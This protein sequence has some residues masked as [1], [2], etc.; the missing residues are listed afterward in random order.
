MH[1]LHVARRLLAR[2]R[3]HRAGWRGRCARGALAHC[4]HPP[5]RSELTRL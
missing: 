2:R 4:P 5:T 1:G 3:A